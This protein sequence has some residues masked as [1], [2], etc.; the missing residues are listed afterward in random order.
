MLIGVF[1]ISV[2]KAMHERVETQVLS[3]GEKILVIG[4]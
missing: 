2:S 3:P 4:E 1:M